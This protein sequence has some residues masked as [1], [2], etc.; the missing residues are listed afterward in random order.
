MYKNA[1]SDMISLIE[2][3][4]KYFGFYD[5]HKAGQ[6]LMEKILE[7][8]FE[9]YEGFKEQVLTRDILNNRNPLEYDVM[10]K[11]HT[12]YLTDHKKGQYFTPTCISSL[13]S[14]LSSNLKN[15]I[16]KA[17]NCLTTQSIKDKQNRQW[18][19]YMKKAYLF[20][21]Y[22]VDIV[23]NIRI[24]CKNNDIDFKQ[25]NLNLPIKIYEPAAGTGS[26]IISHWWD[27][28]SAFCPGNLPF[29]SYLAVAH[30]ISEHTIPF[31]LFNL[32]YRGIQSIVIH[33]DCLSGATFNV[34]TIVPKDED[35]N[36]LLPY[37]QITK[38][39]ISK[40]N[41]LKKINKLIP[42]QPNF[43]KYYKG[44]YKGYHEKVLNKN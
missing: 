33:G 24:I 14:K 15:N 41:I 44:G 27:T 18:L 23:E 7:N 42:L 3:I 17:I 26:M 13:T 39:D 8:D 32:A 16:Q 37:G 43:L 12:F 5:H 30:E 31:L 22:P 36:K 40:P 2:R 6:I 34:Y 1:D 9:L 19:D 35:N 20:M 10:N 11:W 25:F 28:F 29:M 4:D 21:E 38:C